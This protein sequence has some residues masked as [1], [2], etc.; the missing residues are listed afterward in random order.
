MNEGIPL[1]RSGGILTRRG[2]DWTDRFKKIAADAWHLN[3]K[4]AIIDGEVIVP[5]ADGISDFAALQK[6]L[7]S[8]TPSDDVVLYAFVL[9]Y[10]DGYDLPKAPLEERKKLLAPVCTENSIRRRRSKRTA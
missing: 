9:P 6:Q 8:R 10:V 5:T 4:S 7:R 1:K 3:V 2:Y